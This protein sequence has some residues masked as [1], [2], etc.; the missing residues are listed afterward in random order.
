MNRQQDT[1][2]GTSQ[3]PSAPSPVP[4]LSRIAGQARAVRLLEGAVAAPVH[5]YLFRGP[6]GS[7]RRDA[8]VA[9]GAAL[10]CAEGG[11]GR[12]TSCN[13]ALA[14]RHPDV[15]VFEREGASLLVEEAREIGRRALMSPRASRYQ[16]LVLPDFDFVERAA[17]ALLKTIEEPPD[18]TVI[19]LTAEHVSP[20]LRTVASRCVEVPFEALSVT[21][22]AEALASQGC[23]LG[24][25]RAVAEAAGGR[26]D[27]ARL[28]AGDP[29][30]AARLARWRD[31]PA[32]LDGSGTSVARLADELVAAASEPVEVVTARQARELAQLAAEAE[33]RGDRSLPNRRAVE[34]RHRREQRRVRT[35]ELRAGLS[36]LAAGY[37]ER[38]REDGVTPQRLAVAREVLDAID[39]ASARLELNVNETLLVQWLLL[40]VD[41]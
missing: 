17:P 35:D 18:T 28:L 38:L 33:L 26:L 2:G 27:R 4:V 10:V 40:A 23:D 6:P 32:R 39:D 41:R 34:A 12:C 11:C 22:I 14:G 3:H 21:V 19:V 31:I 13:E 36:A 25:A 7:G 29:G 37:R 9:F 5:A 24:V 20:S 16:V 1:P 30:F 15:E 8:A